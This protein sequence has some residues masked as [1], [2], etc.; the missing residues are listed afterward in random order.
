MCKCYPRGALAFVRDTE[1]RPWQ[2]ASDTNHLSFSNLL[3]LSH[4]PQVRGISD[5]SGFFNVQGNGLRLG[6][7]MGEGWVEIVTK[8]VHSGVPSVTR[9]KTRGVS[10]RMGMLRG[11]ERIR[12]ITFYLPWDL[13]DDPLVRRPEVRQWV[14]EH[15]NWHSDLRLGVKEAEETSTVLLIYRHKL[16]STHSLSGTKIPRM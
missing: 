11:L 16:V 9:F 13:V 5:R 6:V 4:Q 2:D 14:V 15:W 12:L 3:L 10:S 8:T 7:T 1:G